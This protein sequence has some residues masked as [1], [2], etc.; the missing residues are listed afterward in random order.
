MTDEVRR[1]VMK[2]PARLARAF[3][4]LVREYRESGWDAWLSQACGQE[5]VKEL[6]GF[7]E[8]LQQDETAVRAALRLEWSNGKSK[9]T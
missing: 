1:L 5:T 3:R 7:A 4:S 6:H 8:S 9:A 2:G